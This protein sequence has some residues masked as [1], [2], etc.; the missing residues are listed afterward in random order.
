MP[1][2]WRDLQ[3]GDR[4]RI[5][6]MPSEFSSPGYFLH[7]DTRK[8]YEHLV[9]EQAI[10]TVETI[11]STNRPLI[12]YIWIQDGVEEFHALAVNHGGLERLA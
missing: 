2:L 7:E 1:E 4:I 11:D 10:L 3:V 12:G 8:L 9:A 5:T 6:Q